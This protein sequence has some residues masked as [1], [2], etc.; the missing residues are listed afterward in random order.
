MVRSKNKGIYFPRVNQ[1]PCISVL[2]RLKSNAHDTMD[3]KVRG[4]LPHGNPVP[5]KMLRFM[6]QV[7]AAQ[8]AIYA[9]R[10]A[11]I[12]PLEID[13]CILVFI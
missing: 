3:E 2:L 8:N 13:F 11:L 10:V 5:K 6:H 4:K 12:A 1:E 9:V 7:F